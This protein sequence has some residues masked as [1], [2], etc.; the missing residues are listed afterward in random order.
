MSV[1]FHTY[2]VQITNRLELPTPGDGFVDNKKVEDYQQVDLETMTA[3]N[4]VTSWENALKK[5]RANIRWKQIINNIEERVVPIEIK[6]NNT[7]NG[8]TA[9][10]APL[11][12]EFYI[13]LDRPDFMVTPDELNVGQTLKNEAA[14]KRLVAR[15]LTSNIY[16]RTLVPDPLS[17]YGDPKS[18]TGR[19]G[20]VMDVN[21]GPCIVAVGMA[22]SYIS[23]EKLYPKS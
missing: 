14:I 11:F 3:T 16:V 19:Y 18:W 20:A 7:G 21:A 1:S 15:A 5:E 12:F 23:V 22:E 17:E 4:Q 10:A 13:V 6:V 8:G 9:N 2:K